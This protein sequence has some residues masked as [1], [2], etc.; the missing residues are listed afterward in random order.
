MR[1]RVHLDMQPWDALEEVNTTCHAENRRRRQRR[2]RAR[3]SQ[4]R[5]PSSSSM[6][7]RSHFRPKRNSD[8][9]SDHHFTILSRS[10][11][12][13]F[14]VLLF[15]SQC[16]GVMT[17]QTDMGIS[18]TPVPVRIRGNPLSTLIPF[19]PLWTRSGKAWP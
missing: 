9:P 4:G 1:S 19:D 16:P 10:S 6:M 3:G 5:N 8:I 17:G 15:L 18:S 11:F 7:R 13:P 14:I 12:F 2:Q